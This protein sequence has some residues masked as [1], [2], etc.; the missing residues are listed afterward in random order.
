[1][2]TITTASRRPLRTGWTLRAT[3]GP[4]PTSIADAV[5]AAA[6][7][8]C[9]HTDL[10]AAGLIPDPYLD[11]NEH[12]LAWV[13]RSDWEYR[14]TF[15]WS[16]D[17]HHRHDIVFEGLDTV[18]AVSL[19][20]R[21]L[22][23]TANQHRTYRMPV[24]GLLVDGENELIVSFTSP[25]R[26]ADAQS[27]AIGYRPHTN[28]HPYNAIRK[29]ACNF[30]W[31]WGP[32]LVTAGIWR[33]VWL[34]SWSE[35]R[36]AQVRPLTTV[37]GDI[38]RVEVHVAV[39]WS[40]AS[41]EAEVVA[42]V[43]A[44]SARA[45]L[46]PDAPA[47]VLDLD[48]PGAQRWWP[49]GHGEQPLYPVSVQLTID[50]HPVDAWHGRVGFRTVRLDTTPDEFGTPFVFVIN[51][52][53]IFIRGANWIPDDAFPHRV[54]RERYAERI[55][56]AEQANINLL[57]VWGGGIY[58]SEDFYELCDERGI[59]TWQDFLFACAA[60]SEEEPLRSEVEAEAR[61]NIARLLPHP[62]L[63]LWNGNNENYVG[64]HHWGW[65]P[66]LDG[67][68]WGD[69]YYEDLLPR[70]V[71]AL[72][73]HRPY[74]PGS[75]WSGTADRDPRDPDHGSSHLWK[76]W[77][78][79]PYSE[80]RASVP[81]FVAEFGWQGPPTWT[82]L[83]RALSDDPLTP[84]SPGMQVHQK[85]QNGNDKLIDG[86]VRHLPLPDDMDDWHW[87]MSLN[88]AVAVRVGIEH[89]RSWTPRCFGAVVWQLN[90]CWPVTSWAAIDGDG[91]PRPLLYAIAHAF[92]DRLLTIQP[93]EQGL[94]VV[95]VNDSADEWT[96][97]ITLRRLSY[98]GT[99]LAAESVSTALAPR[100]TGTYAIPPSLA[101]PTDA[102]SELLIATLGSERALW[103]FAEY[104]DSALTAPELRATAT[105]VDGGYSVH[106]TATTLVRE[107]S[108]L[109]DRV[110]PD[111]RV[112]DM[113]V[114]L[115]PGESV[116]FL[117]TGPDGLPADVFTAP[118][119]LRSA[120][121]LRRRRST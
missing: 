56:Q 84:E 16:P 94:A 93:R 76:P 19:N 110:H 31:D 6:V 111:A 100:A 74:T 10:L 117:V 96:G 25:I 108:L 54:T 55:A 23:Q 104:R 18:A 33:P 8:G 101:A 116:T 64:L 1:M 59:M 109:A 90:D 69:G 80:Y 86:L 112:D 113:L 62:S 47:V 3:G 72:D 44:Y 52:R 11:E 34:H 40:G 20:G 103:Y 92:A 98:D 83:R 77:N 37:V 65:G 73:P 9:V 89:F 36:L 114:T 27:L 15:G 7:P 99:E 53:P 82:T 14:T 115:L 95:A 78:E 79:R 28:P 88:Q 30:G 5:I 2:T 26:F 70:L 106:V 121:D 91:R 118:P 107:L 41:R 39:E 71:A 87:A 38:G 58:E 66:R 120:N 29:M 75:P 81:R 63:V 85:A 105:A 4:T 43:G 119:V 45:K 24:D 51:D 21:P 12:V 57:R 35:A 32:D 22:A 48:V 97:D 49:R 67:R 102:A 17:G 50:G 61:D 46:A 68:S 13:G 42:A 60:Y